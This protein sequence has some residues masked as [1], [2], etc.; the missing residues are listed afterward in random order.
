MKGTQ[1]GRNENHLESGKGKQHP[2][3][4]TSIAKTQLAKDILRTLF[5]SS[6]VSCLVNLATPVCLSG[7]DCGIPFLGSLQAAP[8]MLL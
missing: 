3:M 1:S 5:L 8:L 6:K 7:K 4:I 2:V